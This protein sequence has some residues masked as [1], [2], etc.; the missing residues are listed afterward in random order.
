MNLIQKPSSKKRA[1]HST[2]RSMSPHVEVIDIDRGS[3]FGWEYPTVTNRVFDSRKYVWSMRAGCTRPPDWFPATGSEQLEALHRM[4]CEVLHY[5]GASW[6]TAH[7]PALPRGIKPNPW[8]LETLHKVSLPPSLFRDASHSAISPAA[9]WT[10]GWI[11]SVH[12][13]AGRRWCHDRS[14]D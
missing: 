6:S 5:T 10:A 12:W 4:E 11:P 7:G 3:A 9:A 1:E 13:F 14:P 8:G 2:S